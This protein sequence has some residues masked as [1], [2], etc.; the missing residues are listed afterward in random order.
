VLGGAAILAFAV[1]ASPASAQAASVMR[2]QTELTALESVWDTRAGLTGGDASG[3][4]GMRIAAQEG[5]SAP[6]DHAPAGHADVVHYGLEVGPAIAVLK[7]PNGFSDP[8]R[9]GRALRDTICPVLE[10]EARARDLPAVFFARLVWQESRFNPDALSP[11]GAQG[12]AQFMPA[13]AAERGLLDAFDPATALAE[14]AQ[15]LR[16]LLDEFGN[17]GLAAAA[18]NAG[19]Q[20]V[21]DWLA[22][23]AVLP[24]E[25]E[26]YVLAITGR[27][28][29]EWAEADGATPALAGK[30]V[31]SFQ[32]ACRELAAIIKARL[33]GTPRAT[34]RAPVVP[35]AKDHAPAGEEG[36]A[37]IETRAPA[38]P[39]TKGRKPATAKRTLPWGVQVAGDFSREKALTAYER[40]KGRFS[41]VLSTH[42]PMVVQ[43]KAPG[44]GT[45]PLF[46]VRLGAESREAADQLCERLRTAGGACMVVKN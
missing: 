25:T 41:A 43:A 29:A 24:T 32:T 12:I 17:L 46:A 35:R 28:A 42:E 4:T 16:D 2:V 3:A 14:S 30:E 40:M 33:P 6:I 27:S 31:A 13:T 36:A 23:N 26:D 9:S 38:S 5:L 22:G 34:K 21:R 39:R 1:T 37:V 19:P 7:L 8:A 11:K 44:R 20:R 18:Y 15:F 45:T 10:N